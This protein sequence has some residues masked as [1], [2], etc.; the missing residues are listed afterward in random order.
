MNACR[1]GDET[2]L[3]DRCRAD[4]MPGTFREQHN[5]ERYCRQSE[6][7]AKFRFLRHRLPWSRSLLRQR[8]AVNK[9]LLPA[10]TM[11]F[12]CLGLHSSRLLFLRVSNKQ[13]HPDTGFSQTE[14]A[15][16]HHNKRRRSSGSLCRALSSNPIENIRV[17]NLYPVAS[18]KV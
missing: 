14:H 6:S 16:S 1:F 3:L 15:C 9:V 5:K 7:H 12:G 10:G 13:L 11:S 18:S 2:F 8:K 4:F 17:S